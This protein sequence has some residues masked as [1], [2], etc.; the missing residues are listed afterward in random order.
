MKCKTFIRLIMVLILW[1]CSSPSG[2]SKKP[3]DNLG[4]YLL[5]DSTLTTRD[6]I[7]AGIEALELRENPLLALDEIY[8]YRWANH[9]MDIDSVAV[10]RFKAMDRQ[11]I[12][13]A[14]RPFV[15]IVDDERI[16]LG[17]IYPCYSSY[18]PEKLPYIEVAPFTEMKINKPILNGAADVRNDPR[19]YEKLKI[20]N[21][22]K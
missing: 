3:C 2:A 12:S 21:K 22:L 15:F 6:A 7:S 13:T 10:R 19:I 16:Y 5:K 14:G 1:A 17:N 8:S 18:M 9:S 20:Y 11:Q 4:I